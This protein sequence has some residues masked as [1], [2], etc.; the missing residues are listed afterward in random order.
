MG[1]SLRIRLII[2]A[3]AC[4]AM[5]IISFGE[6]WTKLPQ[7]LSLEW[8]RSHGISPWGVLGLCALCLWLKRGDILPK[9]QT[10]KLSLPSIL[11]GAALLALSI[12]LSRSDN[13][14]VFLMLLGWLGTF[15]IIF[16]RACIVPAILLAIYGFS[17]AFPI[18]VTGWL[19]EPS[20]IVIANT[21]AVIARILGF[22]VTSEGP[23]LIFASVTGGIISAT[24]IPGCAG[25]D[26]IGVFIVLFSLM[27]LDIRLPLKRAWYILLLGLIGTW[28]LNILRIMVTVAAGY[29][30]GRGALE[31]VHEN[32]V[33][34]IF[35]L[36]YALFVYI[37]FRQAR[38]QGVSGK[39]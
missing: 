9:M 5:A 37:Y 39:S 10:G 19:G 14:L 1:F 4:L 7:W 26:T 24:I 33:Y 30:W 25:Y 23:V 21:I 38:K 17:V 13:F 31:T 28:L 15:T 18:L 22:P 20:A 16:S 11:A 27:M 12:F 6:L 36:W 32:A 3:A 34:I 35:P 2:W 29:Y 8:L